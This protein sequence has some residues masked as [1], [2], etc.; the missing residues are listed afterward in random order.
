MATIITTLKQGLQ[1]LREEGPS[2]FIRKGSR[3]AYEST[4]RAYHSLTGAT[5]RGENIYDRDWDTLV[6]LDACRVDLMNDVRDDYPF[7]ENVDTF[8][9]LSSYSLGW[10]QRTF[11]DEYADEMRRTAYV[12]GNPFTQALFDGEEFLFLDEVWR[13]GWDDSVGSIPPRPITDRAISVAREHDPDRLIIHYMQ[14]HVPFITNPE[15]NFQRT[16][17]DGWGEAASETIWDH[18]RSGAITHDEMWDG[19]L[20]NLRHVLDDVSVLL[21]NIDA[22]TVVLTADHGNA[23]GEY[24]LYGHP[25][26]IAIDAL[27]VVPW[28]RTTAS[29]TGSH[30]PEEYQTA[31]T[32]DV[33][34]KLRSLGYL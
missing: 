25:R 16:S 6:I 28:I 22:E 34:E 11:T 21:E 3:F 2:T 26:G 7:I 14:P 19:Y 17:P 5:D 10:M 4:F 29:D 33:Q 13:Y 24:E 23:V 12:T 27:R 15:L 18:V 30:T 1:V 9:T 20:N 8:T 32:G 31:T